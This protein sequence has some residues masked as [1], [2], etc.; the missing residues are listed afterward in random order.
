MRRPGEKDSGTG[1]YPPR[2]DRPDGDQTAIRGYSSSVLSMVFIS[3][4]RQLMAALIV[5]LID[6][7]A[8]STVLLPLVPPVS[9]SIGPPTFCSTTRNGT[10]PSSS[11]HPFVRRLILLS[12]PRSDS[13]TPLTLHMPPILRR[14]PLLLQPLPNLHP[15]RPP[16]HIPSFRPF[17]IQLC[18]HT[19]RI[20]SVGCTIIVAIVSV[21]CFGVARS[22]GFG[23]FIQQ[24]WGWWEGSNQMRSLFVR[25]SVQVLVVPRLRPLGLR[26]RQGVTHNDSNT[27]LGQDCAL[28][29]LIPAHV[30]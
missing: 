8:E 13:D 29:I 14:L 11:S 3:S 27:P 9:Q 25:P 18:P 7:P 28:P 6:V 30:A 17:R 1:T 5:S 15:C 24:D 2:T 22:V 21:C 23:V 12:K 26:G 16:F 4:S 20:V 19:T 10:T